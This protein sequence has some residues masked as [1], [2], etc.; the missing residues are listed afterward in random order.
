MIA[1][2]F[3]SGALPD[4]QHTVDVL[5][6]NAETADADARRDERGARPDRRRRP[7]IM[8]GLENPLA[9]PENLPRGGRGRAGGA[10]RDRPTGGARLTS[11]RRQGHRLA[12][13]PRGDDR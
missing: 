13:V 12:A 3:G 8:L 11:R 1:G 6:R 2:W 10:Y 5:N 9:V 4:S 7:A